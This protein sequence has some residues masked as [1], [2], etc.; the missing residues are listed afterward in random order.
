MVR[1]FADTV[2]VMKAGE[3]VERGPTAQ[4]FNNPQHP[5]TQRLLAANLDPDPD[6]QAQRRL[7]STPANA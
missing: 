7:S 2:M 4:I 3:I 5:Y 1:D 6:M